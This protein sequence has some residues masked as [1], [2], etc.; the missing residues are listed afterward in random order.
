MIEIYSENETKEILDVCLPISGLEPVH[1]NVLIEYMWRVKD[2]ILNHKKN[3]I[4]YV[5]VYFL[6][7][8]QLMITD[9]LKV[10]QPFEFIV[11][12]SIESVFNLGLYLF[13]IET[14]DMS[15]A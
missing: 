5:L 13:G 2:V 14:I 7:V 12:F 10:P 11:D 6:K 15:S 8:Y 9:F 1:G 3:G 4:T